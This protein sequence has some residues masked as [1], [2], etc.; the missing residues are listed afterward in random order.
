M[1]K[2]NR[3]ITE[4]KVCGNVAEGKELRGFL[5]EALHDGPNAVVDFI[6]VGGKLISKMIK[7]L[8]LH[9][10][11]TNIDKW[12]DE[13]ERC[14]YKDI[15]V[16]YHCPKCGHEWKET[17]E[18][19][20]TEYKEIIKDYIDKI[21]CLVTSSNEAKQQANKVI[22][23]KEKE[24]DIP[25]T[26]NDINMNLQISYPEVETLI[27]EK[28]QQNIKLAFFDEQTISISKHVLIKDVTVNVSILQ[29][30][31][32]NI[33][34]SYSASTGIEWIIKGAMMW[35]K[36]NFGG[37]VEEQ[38]GNKL[39]LHLDHV[40]QLAGVLSKIDIQSLRF[41]EEGINAAFQLKNI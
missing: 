5:R 14:I 26:K 16:E 7:G 11:K 4:C 9:L 31:D 1:S 3:Y 25:K 33:M 6:P 40:E 35:F 21:K 12:G 28:L 24:Q 18:L 22:D 41:D 30:R 39:L 37:I 34:V 23:I 13:L 17:H 29:V 27:Q 36:D 19:S 38:E 8:A 15:Q 20:E 32:N 10:V 2:E